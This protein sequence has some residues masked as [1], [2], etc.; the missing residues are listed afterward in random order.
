MNIVGTKEDHAGDAAKEQQEL[1]DM[2]YKIE[3]YEESLKT[4]NS[5]IDALK[6]NK[7]QY[8]ALCVAQY[9][10]EKAINDYEGD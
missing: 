7:Q 8:K 2:G 4:V 1:I 3:E 5:L 9:L 10:I 6:S